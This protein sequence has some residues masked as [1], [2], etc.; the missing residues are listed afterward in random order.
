MLF[1]KPIFIAL[2][3]LVASG[4][5]AGDRARLDPLHP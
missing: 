5:A 1:R 3:I 2:M 4:A